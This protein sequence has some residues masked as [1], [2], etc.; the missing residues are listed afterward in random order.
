MSEAATTCLVDVLEVHRLSPHLVR[1]VLAGAGARGFHSL[2][3]PD[4]GCVL[5]FPVAGTGEDPQPGGGRWYTVR[6]F[7]PQRD[8]MT[9]DIVV[10]PG[11]VGGEWAANAQVG[12]RLLIN[13]QNSWYRRPETA[14]WQLLLGDLA[15]LPAIGRIVEETAGTVPTS[16]VI[17][18]PGSE[19]EQPIGDIDIEWLHN[20]TL[21]AGGSQLGAAIRRASLPDGPGYIYVAGEAA[22]TRA[23]RKYLRHEVGLPTGS[24]GVIG[25]WRADA[26]RWQKRSRESGVDI[27]QLYAQAQAAATDPEDV[28]DIYERKLDE[29]GL[30]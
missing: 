22:A 13:H 14:R 27:A 3:V 16:A 17:E 19:D 9:V 8:L 6:R 26:E 29:A 18:V 10:H 21:T 1:T 30:L 20:P 12:D 5:S 11:G 4:E 23:V 25:Y 24:Y 2:E 7:D 28:R 15:A